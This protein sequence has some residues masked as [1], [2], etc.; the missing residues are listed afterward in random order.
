MISD[1]WFSE[2]E[3]S[4]VTTLEY[5]LVLK[6]SAPFPNLNCTTSSQNESLEGVNDFPA[7]YVHM[8]AAPEVGNTLDNTEI[9]AIRA[10]FELQVYSNKSEGE[11]RKIL[12]ACILEMK[13][14]HFNTTIPDPQSA[15]GKYF[16]LARFTRIIA[17]GDKDIVQ[18]LES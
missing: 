8:L 3:S 9:S 18:T 4:I 11:C 14:L 1:T 5:N 6:D 2:I 17:G 16:A 13:K 15:G 7:L 10:T 12:N